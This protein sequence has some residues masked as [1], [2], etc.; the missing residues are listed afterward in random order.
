MGVLRNVK[1]ER[2]AQ[3]IATSAR[4][5][6]SNGRCYSEAGFKTDDRSADACA[7][8][9]LTKA[10]VSARIEEL[11]TPTVRKTRATIDSLSQQF[12][13]VFEGAVAAEQFGAAGNAAGLKAKLLGFMREKIEFGRVGEFDKCETVQDVV[14]ALMDDSDPRKTLEVLDVMRSLV[15]KQIAERAHD[16]TP[17]TAQPARRGQPFN[18]ADVGSKL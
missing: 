7:A 11:L 10:N 15:A 16:V 9:L 13:Q 4:T 2:F 1:H 5:K 14:D 18:W 8:R 3:N 12:D 6:W 17:A